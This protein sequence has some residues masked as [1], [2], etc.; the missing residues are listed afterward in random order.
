MT[1]RGQAVHCE[2]VFT[3]HGRTCCRGTD[4]AWIARSNRPDVEQALV[5]LVESGNIRLQGCQLRL[6]LLE[7]TLLRGY[8]ALL[9]LEVGDLTL[10]SCQ[11]ILNNAL[12]FRRWPSRRV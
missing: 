11:Q 9:C 10:I 7:C 2:T 12:S 6:N 5:R 1:G 8:V 4:E 3:W